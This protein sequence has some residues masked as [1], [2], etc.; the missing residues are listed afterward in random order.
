MNREEQLRTLRVKIREVEARI[1]KKRRMEPSTSEPK[2]EEKG[3][4][5]TKTVILAKL[6]QIPKFEAKQ[7]RISDQNEVE[8][9]IQA[10]SR[11][12][13]NDKS[14]KVWN[15]KGELKVQIQGSQLNQNLDSESQTTG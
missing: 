8:L 11:R 10:H 1:W 12:P 6:G 3:K 2:P 5:L 13:L 14:R 7:V 4:K 15:E 9:E